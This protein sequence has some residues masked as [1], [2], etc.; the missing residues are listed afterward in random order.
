MKDSSRDANYKELL[1]KL[2]NHWSGDD[3]DG[4]IHIEGDLEFLIGYARILW[5][6]FLEHDTCIFREEAF[7]EETYQGFMKQTNQDRN[8]VEAVMNHI[9]ILDLF[10]CNIATEPKPSRKLISHVGQL[11]KEMWSA[12]LHRDYPHKSITVSFLENP[13]DD[14]IGYQVTFFQES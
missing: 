4:W 9:H 10:S 14:L 1:P 11:L 2:K 6:D 13:L 7:S 12:K 8:A 3:I 5:P